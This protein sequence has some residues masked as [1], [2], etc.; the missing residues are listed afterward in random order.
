MIKPTVNVPNFC[1]AVFQRNQTLLFAAV[2]DFVSS[3]FESLLSAEIVAFAA[4]AS[5]CFV[6]AS[7]VLILPVGHLI[8][9]AFPKIGTLR[10]TCIYC[11]VPDGK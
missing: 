5:G 10:R 3:S 8:P 4:A 11:E 1:S 6:L 7:F 9:A 2:A